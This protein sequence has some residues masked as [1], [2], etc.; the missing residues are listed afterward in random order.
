M[1]HKITDITKKI[2]DPEVE[3]IKNQLEIKKEAPVRIE[4]EKKPE[5]PKLAEPVLPEK[6]QAK[7]E[8]VAP[9]PVAAAP[10]TLPAKSPVIEK[11]E[12]VLEEDLEQIYFQMPAAKQAEFAQAGEETASKIAMLL[13]GV[14]IKVKKILELVVG[15]LKMIPGVNQ[16]FL[17]Q[18][19]KIK[20]DKIL[21]LKA[22]GEIPATFEDKNK[23]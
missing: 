22:K 16:Y 10:A 23:I 4:F 15:W 14:K 7:A 5:A 21:E 18:E 11:I 20:T 8:E 12:D 19:A 17:E 9:Y 2:E 13:S 6:V 3:E 1:P